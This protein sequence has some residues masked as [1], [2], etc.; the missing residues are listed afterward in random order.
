MDVAPTTGAR[1]LFDDVEAETLWLTWRHVVWRLSDG[2]RSLHA[3]LPV[4]QEQDFLSRLDAGEYDELVRR[5]LRRRLGRRR[6][7]V[8]T[9][10]DDGVWWHEVRP[11][12]LVPA[13]RTRDGSVPRVSRRRAARQHRAGQVG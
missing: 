3:V 7:L 13:E 6:L 5:E 9:Q 11:G 8:H 12:A 1:H 10:L 2:Q 4:E